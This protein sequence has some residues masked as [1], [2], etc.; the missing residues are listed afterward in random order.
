[1]TSTVRSG[2]AVAL[3]GALTAALAGA[4][5][6]G[7]QAALPAAPAGAAA[8]PSLSLVWEQHIADGGG[9]SYITLSSPTE[10]TLAGGASVVVGDSH[11]DVYAYHLATGSSVPGWPKDVGAGVTSTPSA[12]PTPGSTADTIL[13]GTGN[14]ASSCVGGYQWLYPSGAQSLVS[15]TNPST[16]TAC[17]ANGVQA[18]MA[19]GTLQ[20]Q[21]ATVAGSLGQETY[22]MN[23]A[24]R[25]VL[26]GFPWFQA[27]SNFATP[28][29]GHVEGT[30]SNQIVEGGASTAGK[31][32][33]KTYTDGGHIRILTASGGL[34]CE[35][36]T[37][38]SVNSSPA[39][40]PF[41][42]GGATGIVAGTGPTYPT[43][44]QHDE[45]IAVNAACGQVWADKL[46]GTTGYESPAL[47]DVLGNGQLQVIATTRTGGV[48]ALD[49]ATGSELWHATLSH[50]IIGSP[51]TMALG[52]GHEDV[53]VA[54][55]NGLDI[56]TGASGAVLVRTVMA[57]TGFENAPLVTKDANGTIGVTIAG[58]QGSGS[59]VYH[60]EVKTSSGTRVD[61]TDTWPQFHHDPQLTGDVST[62]ITGPAPP[63]NTY[64]RI[65]GAT[66]DATAAAELEH[67]FPSGSCPG[68]TGDRPVVLATDATYPDA[69][70]SAYL[71]RSLGT[72]TL[73]TP[74]NILSAPTLAAIKAEGI[75]KVDVV[76]GPL[77]V[78]TAVVDQLESTE[79]TACGGA[80]LGVTVPIKVTRI[81]GT[82]EY[83]TAEKIAV[84]ASATGGVG[85]ASFDG[86]Y[87]GTNTSGG[88][89]R[90]NDTAG[91][92]SAAPA[93]AT[94]LPTAIVATGTGF[95]DAE[96]AST[97]AYAERFPIL[98]TTPS[99]L[100][101]QAATA[102]QK[103]GIKQVIV[104][105]GQFAVSNA[106]VSSLESLGL[107]VL[108]VAGQTYSG[109]ST[110]LASFESSAGA[111]LGWAGTGSVT[112]ARGDAFSDGLAG[113]I[114][115]AD[116]P[117]SGAPTPL[118][119]ALN[120]DTAGTALTTFLQSAGKT[121][122][123]G[124]AVTQL[125]VLG[126]PDAVTQSAIN[127]MG[128][129]LTG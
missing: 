97:L 26:P 21:T 49:G 37:N 44:S 52:T 73:L 43:A 31:A 2:F 58:H 11:G 83:T 104:M 103:L 118:V 74:H 69:L 35:D 7:V 115:A 63:F 111:G 13:V 90:Y 10:A 129:A 12:A 3:G 100:S 56:L 54:S 4:A 47:A 24:S 119:L 85:A 38:E 127:V 68:A 125:T 22:A 107:A 76:G 102:L 30:G 77:A 6:L 89:G 80:P 86:A 8:A 72:G 79:A 112:V 29:I 64:T 51:V 50:G 36:T 87:A 34:V 128:Q 61:G 81:W 105:G 92:G 15:A 27:D 46:G 55:V 9:G 25:G 109:T 41:L 57:T 19:V 117:G 98:L 42:S 45:V 108:R 5:S 82:T 88:T 121:G 23:A 48:Y 60:F 113:A 124:A 91:L 110:E 95:Q 114:V 40:G 53:L 32:Y 67:Q 120:P 106:V 93:A 84:T 1:M 70:A 62:P 65:Y 123:G 17:R 94:A 59:I 20:G 75:T 16:D 14:A 33:G 39:V 28:A 78:T 99:A 122:L 71:A 116:G 126:G 96:S 66:A 18:S 101:A